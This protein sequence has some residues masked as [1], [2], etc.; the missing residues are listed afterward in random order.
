MKLYNGFSDAEN[1]LIEILFGENKIDNEKFLNINYDLFVKIS[2]SH[3]MIP[4]IYSNLKRKNYLDKIPLDLKEYF[5]KIYNLNKERNENLINEANDLSKGLN[6]NGIEFKFIKGAAHLM[7]NLYM[8]LGE[9]MIGDIDFLVKKED[10]DDV[11]KILYSYGYYNKGYYKIWKTKHLP[12]FFNN[13]KVFAVEPHSEAVIYRKR[14]H[15]NPI[16]IIEEN[17]KS[18]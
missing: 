16:K 1:L 10:L 9:R 14:K 12:R 6:S 4:C 11:S 3:L 15:I 13:N 18:N 8:G 2:S 17:W 7:N 5:R